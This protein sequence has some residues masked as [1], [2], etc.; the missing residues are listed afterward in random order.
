MLVSNLKKNLPSGPQDPIFISDLLG[1]HVNSY[2]FK[3]LSE[4]RA[5]LS[6]Q[7]SMF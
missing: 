6:N 2:Y 7:T 1:V 4:G 5:I 3:A